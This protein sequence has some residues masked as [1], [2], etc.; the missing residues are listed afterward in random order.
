MRVGDA[1]AADRGP[2]SVGRRRFVGRASEVEQEVV[3]ECDQRRY[4]VLQEGVE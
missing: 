4:W 1:D 2:E 3:Q